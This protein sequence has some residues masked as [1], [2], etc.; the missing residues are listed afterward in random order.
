MK[1]K[2]FFNILLL[3]FLIIF[4]FQ[5]VNKQDLIKF[6]I[7]E[8]KTTGDQ[9]INYRIKNNLLVYSKTNL[10]YSIKLYIDTSKNREIKD[11]N[12]K[13]EISSY[14]IILSTNVKAILQNN[15]QEINFAV[16]K[17]GDYYV[18]ARNT[19]TLDNQKRVEKTLVNQMTN[20]ILNGLISRIND[21]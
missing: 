18:G 4:G 20:D 16:L 12:S 3:V 5:V 1:S 21:L 10:P 17:T 14:R 11:K 6:S 9:K 8:I 7:K 2:I 19:L 15:E 13:N